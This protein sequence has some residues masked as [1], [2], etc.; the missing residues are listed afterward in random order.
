MTKKINFTFKNAP[1]VKNH[2]RQNLTIQLIQV[3]L[4]WALKNIFIYQFHPHFK[5]VRNTFTKTTI[6]MCSTW[7]KRNVQL[8]NCNIEKKS[9][10]WLLKYG[11][12]TG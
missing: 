2:I 5:N 12:N 3:F 9:Q 6:H 8:N 11:K 7:M 1:L 4:Q 10:V